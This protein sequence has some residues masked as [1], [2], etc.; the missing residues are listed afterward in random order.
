[1]KKGKAFW[2]EVQMLYEQSGK[3]SCTVAR[4]CG[5]SPAAVSYHAKTEG[6][7]KQTPDCRG[8]SHD[9]LKEVTGKLSQA[10]VREIG[11]LEKQEA[12]VKTIRE[13][14]ALVKE[15]RQLSKNVEPEAE[16]CQDICVEWGEDTEVWSR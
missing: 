7:R 8:I 2:R 6:W 13:L 15:L 1:M 4:E 10:A 11:R 12:D 9:Q 16:S 14:T 5:V 3:S